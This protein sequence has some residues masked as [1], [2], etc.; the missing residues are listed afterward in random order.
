MFEK[1]IIFPLDLCKLV[2]EYRKNVVIFDEY[3]HN[4]VK[5]EDNKYRSLIRYNFDITYF[6][7]YVVNNSVPI[8][9]PTEIRLKFIDIG[10]MDYFRIGITQLKDGEDFYFFTLSQFSVDFMECIDLYLPECHKDCKFHDLYAGKWHCC[11]SSN[12]PM[13]D[14]FMFSES[15]ADLSLVVEDNCQLHMVVKKKQ[16]LFLFNNKLIKKISCKNYLFGSTQ[17]YFVQIRAHGIMGMAEIE[18]I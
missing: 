11:I 17:K 16:L 3:D 12:Y 4:I 1:A 13:D 9:V 18:C 10:N 2:D 8:L 6:G 15:L 5:I 7:D 14:F